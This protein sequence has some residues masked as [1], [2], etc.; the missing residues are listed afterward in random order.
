[1]R[2]GPIGG[3]ATCSLDVLRC[4]DTWCNLNM[5]LKTEHY[6]SSDQKACNFSIKISTYHMMHVY[7]IHDQRMIRVYIHIISELIYLSACF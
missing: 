1:M 7:H 3:R 2:R 6:V 5:R 4:L